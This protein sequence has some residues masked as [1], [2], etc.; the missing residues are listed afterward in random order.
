MCVA[1][2]EGSRF[3][4]GAPGYTT[5]KGSSQHGV[6]YE[7]VES[8]F[9]AEGARAYGESN[10]AALEWIGGLID[11]R[12]IDCDWRPKP[13]YAYGASEEERGQLARE[14]VAARPARP[15]AQYTAGT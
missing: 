8:S 9:G 1:G 15:P 2:I 13:S 7:S 6:H 12:G 4:G 5:A 14:A 11:E 3:V 10:Q